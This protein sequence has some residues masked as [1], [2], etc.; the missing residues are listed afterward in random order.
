M[1]AEAM[2]QLALRPMLPSD[3]PVL[4]RIFRD[5]VMELTGEDYSEEQQKAWAEAA[6]DVAAF[7]AMLERQVALVATLG[8]S[9]IGFGSLE[10]DDRIGLLY[11]HPAA[12]GHGAGSMLADAL[13]KIAGGRGA[14]HLSVDASD[15]A[16]EFFAGRGY[17][18]Q[19]RNQVRRGDAWLTNTTMRKELD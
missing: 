12:I 2:P 11:V 9:P 10:A 3:V 19:Q 6:D 5:S 16:S 4:A 8:G 1:S 13:E 7:G 18:P 14:E 15:T 17:V